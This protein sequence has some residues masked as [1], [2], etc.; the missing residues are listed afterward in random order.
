FNPE[1]Y[2]L[3]E[4]QRVIDNEQQQL[5]HNFMKNNLLENNED[6]FKL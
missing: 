6:S 5:H 1:N 3:M 2:D 4:I